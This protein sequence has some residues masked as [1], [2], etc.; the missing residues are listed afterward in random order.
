M[1]PV[2]NLTYLLQKEGMKNFGLSCE[3][4]HQKNDCRWRIVGKPANP[5]LPENS[6]KNGVCV[7]MKVGDL[8]SCCY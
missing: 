8:D 3:D 6:R 4:T 7:C 1:Y 2:G 5:R